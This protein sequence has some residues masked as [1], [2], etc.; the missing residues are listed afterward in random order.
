MK[1]AVRATGVVSLV[2]AVLLAALVVL[3]WAF[4]GSSSAEAS[5]PSGWKEIYLT[6]L[7]YTGTVDASKE[8]NGAGTTP[9]PGVSSL[10]VTSVDPP[11]WEVHSF[12]WS[13]SSF[14]VTEGDHVT[15]TILGVKGAEHVASI[16]GHVPNFTVDRG[17]T[18]VLEFT[19]GRPG[20]YEVICN[21]HAPI[22]T[23]QMIV[24]PSDR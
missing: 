24:L 11:R 12:A 19:A 9:V 23:G 16:E 15:L 20:V 7:D 3:M 1:P 18:T 22:M 6:T 2:S 4:E 17:A 13:P 10:T 14:V 5:I 21:T 8:A